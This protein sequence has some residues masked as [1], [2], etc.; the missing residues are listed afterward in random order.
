MFLFLFF[1]YRHFFESLKTASEKIEKVYDRAFENLPPTLK[2]LEKTLYQR[3]RNW[4]KGEARVSIRTCNEEVLSAAKTK[5]KA[6][7]CAGTLD[8]LESI[9]RERGSVFLTQYK[10]LSKHNNVQ[11][12]QHTS[13]LYCFWTGSKKVLL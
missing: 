8:E 1:T 11:N 9:M 10:L 13:T 5:V 7:R 12:A 3:V 2:T 4:C 6:A